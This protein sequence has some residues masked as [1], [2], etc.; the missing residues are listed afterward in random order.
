MNL[1]CIVFFSLKFGG[2][3][4][5]FLY[6]DMPTLKKKWGYGYGGDGWGWVGKGCRGGWGM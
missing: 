1:Q 3:R 6:P 4:N 2:Y 5:I